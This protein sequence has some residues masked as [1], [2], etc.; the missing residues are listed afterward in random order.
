MDRMNALI[1]IP[2]DIIIK[3]HSNMNNKVLYL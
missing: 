3:T 2:Q 1:N